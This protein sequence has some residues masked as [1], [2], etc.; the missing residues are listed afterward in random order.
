MQLFSTITARVA[1]LGK[2]ITQVLGGNFAAAATTATAAT[3]GFTAAVTSSAKAG[4]NLVAAMQ[5]L[6]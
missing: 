1:T 5:Q 4:Y 6:A 2:A 3:T